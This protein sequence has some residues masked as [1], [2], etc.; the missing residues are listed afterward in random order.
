MRQPN[1]DIY[2][3]C[4]GLLLL[5]ELVLNPATRQRARLPPPP[6]PPLPDF[7]HDMRLAFDPA[8]SPYYE[9][10]SIPDVPY[11]TPLN[12]LLMESEWPPSPFV[13]RVFSSRTGLWEETPF[14]REGHCHGHP[15]ETV[16]DIQLQLQSQKLSYENQSTFCRGRLYV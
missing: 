7:Y 16:A 6:P 8:V 12:P 4:N 13:L 10:L 2:D 15:V 1:I 14:V 5:E 11:Y 9:V 3:H